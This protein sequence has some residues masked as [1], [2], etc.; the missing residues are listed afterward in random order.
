MLKLLKCAIIAVCEIIL[1]VIILFLPLAGILK[2]LLIIACTGGLGLGAIFGLFAVSGSAKIIASVAMAIMIFSPAIYGG[3]WAMGL[4]SICGD[5]RC[6]LNE[7]K[8]ACTL[9]CNQ[10]TCADSICQIAIG[11]NCKNSNDCQ[12][13][14][15]YSCQPERNASNSMGCYQIICGDSYCDGNETQNTCCTDCG[16]PTGYNCQNNQCILESL[17]IIVSNILFSDDYSATTLYTN[18]TLH[19]PIIGSTGIDHPLVTITIKNNGETK[20]SDVEV[21]IKIG[22]YTDWSYKNVGD[23]LPSAS[24]IV[25][26]NPVFNYN[27]MDI[28]E[29]K[30][31]QVD[32]KVTYDDVQGA[33]HTNYFSDSMD[34][35]SRE[36]MNWGYPGFIAGWITTNDPLVRQ[37]T[38]SAA[39]GLAPG[40]IQDDIYPAAQRIWSYLNGTYPQWYSV[41]YVSDPRG[42]EFVQFPAQT[43]R[44]NAGDCEDL[45]V[46]FATA[47]ESVGIRTRIILISGHAFMLF[48]DSSTCSSGWAVETTMMG[49]SS[50]EQAI[51]VGNNEYNTETILALIDTTSAYISPPSQ[52]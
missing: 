19:Y 43:L 33:S 23:V 51:S 42:I 13:Q 7:C 50:L 29:D 37:L 31:A 22:S 3:A 20:A 47:L 35:I 36:W 38:T 40:Y 24:E 17:N 1:I 11:E 15:G 12:C 14:T 45:A 46:L 18:P 48:C 2:I 32:I 30:T 52:M 10:D 9:D 5:N 39:S 49:G 28:S 21:G 4:T 6:D 27:V 41:Q 44:N 26:F 16:C 34:I 25:Q 8:T